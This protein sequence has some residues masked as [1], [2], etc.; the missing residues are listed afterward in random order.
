MKRR[1]ILTGIGAAGLAVGGT[2]LV[3]PW[4][5][6]QA[7]LLPPIGAAGAQA[8]EAPEVVEM[9][10]G[11]ADAPVTVI[12]YASF[13]C[14]HCASFHQTVLPLI[15][16]N[17]IDT[18]KV[19]FI[20]REVYFDR[21]GLW[22]GMMARCAGEDRYFAVVDRLYETQRDWVQGEPATVAENLRRIGRSVG[23][24]EAELEACLS[25]G[26]MA[27]ALINWYEGNQAEDN[28]SGT[29]SF[30][31]NGELHSNMNYPDFAEILDA[32]VAAAE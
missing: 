5:A 4:Q 22:A 11:D 27:Q 24:G 19:R 15:K 31:I 30:I 8:T 20:Y 14:H 7:P 18:G 2:A 28:I 10:L 21:F 12:E 1:T 26:D 3:A 23:L 29:P 25:D 16:E 32:Q 17:Y 13:T 9:V 6:R